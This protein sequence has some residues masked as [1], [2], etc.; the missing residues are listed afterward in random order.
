MIES[1][2]VRTVARKP[3]AEEIAKI[4]ALL[5]ADKPGEQKQVLEDVFWALLN[6]QEFMF[7]H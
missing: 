4:K 3:T 7:N 2:Y 1:L 5:P 6:S